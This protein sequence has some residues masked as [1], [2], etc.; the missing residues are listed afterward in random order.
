MSILN[1]AIFGTIMAGAVIGLDYYLYTQK[2]A[3]VSQIGG[4]PYASYVDSVKQRIGSTI[5]VAAPEAGSLD[6][7]LPEPSEGQTRRPYRAADGEAV[8]GRAYRH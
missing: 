3:A 2:N 7:F 6:A 8:T 1:A 5:E 4:I